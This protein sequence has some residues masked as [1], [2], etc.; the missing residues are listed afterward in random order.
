MERLQFTGVTK[1]GQDVTRCFEVGRLSYSETTSHRTSIGKNDGLASIDGKP[2]SVVVVDDN[3]EF[4]AL[5]R[6]FLTEHGFDTH[7]VDG[8]AALDPV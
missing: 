2:E 5:L 6:R 1:S 8:S 7:T 3:D 4:R